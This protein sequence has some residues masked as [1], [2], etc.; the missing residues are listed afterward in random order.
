[1]RQSKNKALGSSKAGK[2][3]GKL[4][5]SLDLQSSQLKSKILSDIFIG[6]RLAWKI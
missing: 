3:A 4:L 5:F 2:L 1:M 6:M